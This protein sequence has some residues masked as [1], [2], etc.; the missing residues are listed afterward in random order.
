MDAMEE[1]LR[2]ENLSFNVKPPITDEE[3]VAVSTSIPSN[4]YEYFQSVEEGNKKIHIFQH[5]FFRQIPFL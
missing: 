2:S 5:L 4:V 1:D 3:T